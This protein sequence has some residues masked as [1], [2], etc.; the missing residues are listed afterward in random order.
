VGELS[1]VYNVYRPI[2]WS[3]QQQ[4]AFRISVCA[5]PHKPIKTA[6][7]DVLVLECPFGIESSSGIES[8]EFSPDGEHLVNSLHAGQMRVV[9][10][11]SQRMATS[12]SVPAS[13]LD[14]DR[15]NNKHR[16][17]PYC[18]QVVV[19]SGAE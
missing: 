18:T 14:T 1:F 9:A 2:N 13:E 11:T 10:G 7:R 17:S 16:S 4:S 6:K 5:L 3:W 19:V 8:P 15:F 12:Q